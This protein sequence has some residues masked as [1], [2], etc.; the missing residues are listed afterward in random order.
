MSLTG[1]NDFGDE[2]GAF[3]ANINPDGV[4]QKTKKLKKGDK[5]IS[6]SFSITDRSFVFLIHFFMLLMV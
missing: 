2:T 4:A 1:K 5:L 6:V 3:I